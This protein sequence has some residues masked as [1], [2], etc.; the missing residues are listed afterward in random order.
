MRRILGTIAARIYLAVG[1][2]VLLAI[3][4]GGFAFQNFRDQA[5]EV[6]AAQRA[7]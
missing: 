3:A 7:M 1:A 6:A 4:G 5:A 2:L